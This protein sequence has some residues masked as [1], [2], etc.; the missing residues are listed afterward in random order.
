MALSSKYL[1]ER[2]PVETTSI[3]YEVQVDFGR[4]MNQ[5]IMEKTME[6]PE[7]QRQNIVPANV[8]LPP[9]QPAKAVPYFG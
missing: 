1:K 8:T 2:A 3:L 7:D 9:P 5:I 6:K 4:T